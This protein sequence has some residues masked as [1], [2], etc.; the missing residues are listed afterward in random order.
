MAIYVVAAKSGILRA[1]AASTLRLAVVTDAAAAD[2]IPQPVL[3][4]TDLVSTEDSA[5]FESSVPHSADGAIAWVEGDRLLQGSSEILRSAFFSSSTATTFVPVHL[6]CLAEADFVGLQPRLVSRHGSTEKVN[7]SIRIAGTMKPSALVRESLNRNAQPWAKLHLALLRELEPGAGIELLKQVWHDGKQ[8]SLIAS[9]V[10]RNLVVALLRNKQGKKAEELLTLGAEL[11]PG[12]GEMHYLAAVLWVHRQ[13]PSKALA[14]LERAL[15]MSGGGYVGSG[16]EGSYRSRW[17]LGTICEEMGD[18]DRALSHFIPGVHLRPAFGPSVTAILRQRFS[19]ARASQLHQPLCE[20]ARREPK[21]LVPVFDFFLRH[22]VF[23]PPRRLLRT[24][25][26]A[27]ELREELQRRLTSSETLSRV[28][29]R[30]QTDRPGV[31]LEGS[32]LTLSGHARINHSL[33]GALLEDKSL[34][35]ALEPSEAGSPAA[36]SL[37]DRDRLLA[38]FNRAPARLDLTIRHHWPPDFRPPE[39]GR[40]ACIVVP[41]EHR[42]VPRPWVREIERSVDELWVPSR[43]VASAFIEGGVTAE[44][45]QVVPNGFSPETFHLSLKPWRPTGCRSCVFLFVGGAIR[46]KGLDLLLQAYADAFLADDDVTL[47][48]KET[49][50]NSF[51]AHNSLLPQL[52]R[53]A[54][55]PNV[56]PVILLKEAMDDNAL[57]QL[58]CGCNVLVLPYRGEGFGMPLI[59]AMAC[60]KPVITTAAGPALEFTTAE[61]AYLIPATELPVPDPPPPFR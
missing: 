50:A 55:Q 3:L 4:A 51:Y 53:L 34:D 22:R 10:L 56:A 42:A 46:R 44:R 21:Y 13:K 7:Q 5:I 59:E 43:F 19:R 30:E 26:L 6:P 25:P 9:L 32:F 49:G 48:I 40:L 28:Q 24:L 29:P 36:R 37:P 12:Y 14:S 47:V 39:T 41:W 61:S 23:D 52:Q 15:Q 60:G 18:Q 16:G 58:Y 2:K 45:I 11:Y 57:A 20:L 54:R 17:L 31:V 33:G 8:P 27:P 35:T 38:G 1:R